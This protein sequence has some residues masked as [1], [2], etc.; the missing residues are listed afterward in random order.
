MPSN[1]KPISFALITVCSALFFV[2]FS[3][4][5]SASFME[6]ITNFMVTVRRATILQEKFRF[7][8]NHNG[9]NLD[10]PW[11]P[12]TLNI[13]ENA[14]IL[15]S[16]FPPFFGQVIRL[17]IGLKE[18]KSDLPAL[19]KQFKLQFA[20]LSASSC[21]NQSS[22]WTDLG[23]YGSEAL[24]RGVD[25]PDLLDD[26]VLPSNLLSLANTKGNF[27]EKNPTPGN[28]QVNQNDIIEYDWAIQNNISS[29]TGKSYCFRMVHSDRTQ[30]DGY[31]LYPR[32]TTILAPENTTSAT[33]NYTT[34]GSL[35]LTNTDGSKMTLTV[36]PNYLPASYSFNVNGFDYSNYV[37]QIGTAP[38]G[39][40]GAHSYIYK[41]SAENNY[42]S[43]SSFQQ[44]LAFKIK[45]TDSEISSLN[46]NSLTIYKYDG[47]DWSALSTTVDAANNTATATLASFSSFGLFGDTAAPT[48]TPTPMPASGGGGGS[49]GGSWFLPATVEF[50]GLAY[51]SA[52]VNFLKDGAN[53]GLTL[54]DSNGN[55]SF[56]L[57][58]L[59]G[60]TYN[61]GFWAQ[62]KAD[63]RSVTFTSQVTLTSGSTTKISGIVLPPTVSLSKNSVNLGE[64][65]TVSGVSVPDSQVR[66]Q[67]AS[68]PKDYLARSLLNGDY[69][70]IF[71]TLGLEKGIHTIKAKTEVLKTGDESIF[72][73]LLVFGV[74]IPA[75]QKKC[76]HGADINNDGKINLVDFSIMIYWWGRTLP[77]NSIVDLN[78]DGLLNLAD[79]SILAF[80]WTG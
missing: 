30:L 70:Q 53:A 38:S 28:P 13:D 14:S 51:P 19:H 78:C 48:P 63:R 68:E 74:G 47:T 35:S 23:N 77:E 29:P 11:P 15:E 20:E 54:A 26:S 31:T 45:Y 41:I 6:K 46:E 73:K 55:F 9:L 3:L 52:V 37:D 65:L 36:P 60:G 17:R 80:H 79:F 4:S 49:G 57:S 7:Y 27:K 8:V 69:S 24:W 50:R 44:P 32:I 58:G 40:S 21:S 39:K 22:G 76:F 75:S 61:F 72:S 59:S 42:V 62:D 64:K 56:V 71:S 18:T 66:I 43:S 16:Q 34:G 67:V 25:L 2:L 33:I 1:F 10:D 5:A 12:G